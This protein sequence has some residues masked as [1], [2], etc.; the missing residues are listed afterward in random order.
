MYRTS[1]FVVFLTTLI[2]SSGC[3]MLIQDPEKAYEKGMNLVK[4]RKIESAYKYFLAATKKQPDNPKYHWAAAQI[5]RNQN[6]AFIHTEMT[7]KNGMKSVPVMTNLLRL[8]LFTNK[9]QRT[10]KMISLYNEL[11]DSVKTPLLKAELFSQIGE[12]DSALSIWKSLYATKPSSMLAFKIGRE[13]NIKNET[14]ASREFLENARKAKILDG[15]GY[16]LLASM[17]AY[18]YDYE[19]IE[20]IFNET[21]ERGLYSSEVALEEASFL[22]VSGKYD[23]AT[24]ILS[25]YRQPTPDQ[26]DQLLNHRARINLAF[27]YAMQKDTVK[28]NSLVSDIPDTSP[29]KSAEQR[30]YKVLQEGEKM[31]ST[32]LLKELEEIRKSIPRNPFIELYTARALLKSNQFDKSLKIYQSLPGIYLRSPGILTEYALVL[33]RSGKENEALVALSIMHKRKAFTRASLELFRDL[34]FRKNLLEKSEGTQK[35]L[36]K[37]YDNDARVRFNGAVMALRTGKV[38]S[39]ITLL[40][41]LEKQFPNEHHFRTT[42]IS[43]LIMKGDYKKAL[44]L[45]D[46]GNAPRE[47]IIPLKAQ[48]LKKLGKET[49]SLQLIEIARKENDNTHLSLLHAEML[50]GMD[51]NEDAARIYEELL[52]SEKLDKETGAQSAIIYNNMAW[53]LLQTEKPEKKT[54]I[55]AAERAYQLI[56]SSANILDTYTEALIRFGQ[57]GQCIKILEDSKITQKEPKL[58]YQLGM[59]YEK[60]NDL[61][62]AVRHFISARAMMDSANGSIQ[63]DISKAELERHIERILDKE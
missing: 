3:T 11:P 27:M 35:L 24:A 39:A 13:L 54:V 48:I 34:T 56:P 42:R 62:K 43:A 14:T 9:E 45:C 28:L 50:M 19:G 2:F 41:D 5:A 55:K 40:T 46:S 52:A 22:F 26:K 51:K 57:Y 32:A 63:M 36:E 12:S 58:I 20:E 47:Q 15:A 53:A 1:G 29:F 61:N 23:A 38:D 4:E 21:K 60:K 6:A 33:S 44:A 7:W 25:G 17:R 30:F 10:A 37:L 18:E 16:V 31:E 59:A 8:S 49:E